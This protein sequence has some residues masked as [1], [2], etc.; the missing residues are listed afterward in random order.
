MGLRRDLNDLVRGMNN[1]LSISRTLLLVGIGLV[2]I[3]TT[4]ILSRILNLKPEFFVQ[5]LTGAV[6]LL[7]GIA[8]LLG[9]IYGWGKYLDRKNG[10]TDGKK[11]GKNRP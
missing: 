6:A 4:L 11:T 1:R 10:G 5:A 3:Y 7:G 2:F 9:G 8:A